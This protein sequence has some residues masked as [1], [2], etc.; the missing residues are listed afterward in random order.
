MAK[1]FFS[2][3]FGCKKQSY[4]PRV[5]VQI[6]DMDHQEHYQW[7][8]A[9]I[10]LEKM[11]VVPVWKDDDLSIFKNGI[12]QIDS[13]C[14]D[15]PDVEKEIYTKKHEV[16]ETPP[17]GMVNLYCLYSVE[18]F[19]PHYVWSSSGLIKLT[20]D[21]EPAFKD[22]RCIITDAVSVK[23][24]PEGN[25]FHYWHKF[26]DLVRRNGKLKI[27]RNTDLKEYV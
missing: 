16:V 27:V 19:Q 9:P 17:A 23:I 18:D 24:I 26:Y 14:F 15:D 5:L 7:A 21:F 13:R 1:K 12:W 2:W 25:T 8:I 3:L 11:N 6:I 10:T 20:M 4:H 22:D